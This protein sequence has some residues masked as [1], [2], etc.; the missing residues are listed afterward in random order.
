MEGTTAI[1]HSIVGRNTQQ[2]YTIDDRIIGNS[3]SISFT[4]SRNDE[5]TRLQV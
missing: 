3:P 5:S 4:A 2:R 1:K